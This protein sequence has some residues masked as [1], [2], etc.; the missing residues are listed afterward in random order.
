MTARSTIGRHAG[1]AA[2]AL[3]LCAAAHAGD[4]AAPPAPMPTA[5][6]KECASCHTAYPPSMLPPASWQRLMA[7]LSQHFGTDAS[8]D[9]ATLEQIEGWLGAH[10]G[11]YKKVRRDPTPPP[12]DRIT[13][14]P[15]FEREH[16]EVGPATWARPAIK[17]AS[18]CSACHTLADQGDFSERHIR[19]PR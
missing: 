8:L 2:A 15:W 11:T 9:A 7:N 1:L 17:S 6:V 19:I 5:Y 4:R 3:V 13:R 12:E 10:A 18:N 16:H 14:A